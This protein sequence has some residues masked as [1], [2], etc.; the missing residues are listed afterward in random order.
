MQ[1]KMNVLGI[2]F[3]AVWLLLGLVLAPLDLIGCNNLL[4]FLLS[5]ITYTAD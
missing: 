5:I 2:M 3:R 1:K 4:L